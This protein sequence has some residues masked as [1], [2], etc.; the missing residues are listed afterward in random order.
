KV[1]GRGITQCGL[2]F[3][4]SD[5]RHQFSESIINKLPLDDNENIVSFEN[6]A[7]AA[8]GVEKLA[9]LKLD[10]DNLGLLF[11][12]KSKKEYKILSDSLT[13]FFEKKLYSILENDLENGQIYPVFAG[14]DDCFI[15]GS[16]NIIFET[17]E[18]IHNAFDSF[19][20]ELRK[21]ID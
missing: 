3:S 20:K 2:S 15:I 1:N 11:R 17:A 5:N 6:I 12:D 9:A 4:V 19:Q 14:G 8:E 10:V 16:W 13:V 7:A 18:K 21:K